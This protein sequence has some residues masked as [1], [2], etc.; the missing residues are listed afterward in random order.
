MFSKAAKNA[1]S[2]MRNR[3]GAVFAVLLIAQCAFWWSARPIR[4]DTSV[5][6]TPP[7]KA[8][9]HALTFGDDEF[10]FRVNAFNLQNFGDGFGRN[11]SLRFYDYTKLYQWL[12]L[13]DSLNARSN[14]LPSMTTY[15]FSQTQ[16]PSDVHYL[17]RYLYAHATRDVANKWW[18]LM[19]SIYLSMY[20]VNDMDL[21][22]KVAKPMVDP[23]V[24]VWAQQMVAVVH[25][26]RGEMADAL[27]IMETISDNA[28]TLSD[29]D[30]R[31]MNYFIK[32]RLGK[33]DE[34]QQ[35]K[36]ETAH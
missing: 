35:R 14:M 23:A 29:Q 32:E 8:A 25:E 21:A 33:L 27:R 4:P 5:V 2:L 12:L 34:Y 11:T 1:P 30:L 6:P 26:K 20:K 13:L 19:Q 36:K 18:W 16:N 28:E 22:I 24:P 3:F 7:G 10:Y 15:Y 17:I 9:L 31:Y